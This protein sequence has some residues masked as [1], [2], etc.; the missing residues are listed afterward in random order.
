MVIASA[1]SRA[2]LEACLTSLREQGAGGEI[3][4]IAVSN[5]CGG[6]GRSIEASFPFVRLIEAPPGTT[7]PALRTMGIQAASGRIVALLE[8][9]SIVAPAWCRAIRRAHEAGHEIV[10]GAVERVG[11]HR[12]L[13]WAVYFYE[14]GKYM[15][16][17]IEGASPTLSGNNVS[18]ART[19]LEQIQDEYRDGFFEAFLHERL[20]GR[21]HRLHLAPDA[22]VYHNLNYRAGTVLR[23]TFHHGRHYAGRRMAA[24]AVLTRLGYAAGSMLLPVILPLRIARVVLR[25]GRHLRELTAAMPYLVL[26]MTSWACGELMGYLCGEGESVRQWA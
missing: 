22:V 1:H 25:R 21:G 12:A 9:N 10:G 17:C 20:R 2:G 18:Y 4:V 23:Q 19:V 8:D 26:F 11:R 14:Y 6:A 24:A 13:D 7:V 16:P 15:L 5:C 3:E